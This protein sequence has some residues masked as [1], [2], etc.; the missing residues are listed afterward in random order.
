MKITEE[1]PAETAFNGE[2]PRD[3][4]RAECHTQIRNGG[5]E[6]AVLFSTE[7]V[8]MMESVRLGGD[9]GD[10]ELLHRKDEIQIDDHRDPLPEN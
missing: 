6:E 10:K 1:A 4:I 5:N 8:K 3:E 2:G 9:V 7:V